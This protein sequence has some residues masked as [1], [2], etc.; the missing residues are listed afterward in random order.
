MA[1]VAVDVL[2][3][4]DRFVAVIV[5]ARAA[6]AEDHLVAA[7]ARNEIVEQHHLQIAAM[8]GELRHVVAGKAPGRFAVDELAEAIVEAIFAR[9]HRDLG[10]RVFEAER[11][12]FARG[13]RQNVDA[14][15]DRLEFGRASNTRQAMPARCSIRP[16]VS[17]P[18]PAPMIKTSMRIDLPP[19]V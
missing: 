2:E 4:R 18:M 5:D 16:N 14:D 17:P 13:M 7:C 9:G 3:M 12:E 15:T 1:S 11:A 19:P 6:L 8:D 10:E